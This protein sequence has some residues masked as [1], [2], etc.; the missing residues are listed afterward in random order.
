MTR[1]T[2]LVVTHDRDLAFG[3]A[4]RIAFLS[5]GRIVAVGTPEAIRAS[6]DPLIR[7]FLSA[8]FTRD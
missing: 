8:D 5:E 3:I 4:N 1:A 6:Q 2:T 7:R